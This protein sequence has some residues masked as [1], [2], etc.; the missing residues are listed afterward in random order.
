[1]YTDLQSRPAH[2]NW[3]LSILVTP[4][5]WRLS[6]PSYGFI[7]PQADQLRSNALAETRL[8]NGG[9]IKIN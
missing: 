4:E 8:Q 3:S 9:D 6:V 1:M 5:A 2:P 7:G